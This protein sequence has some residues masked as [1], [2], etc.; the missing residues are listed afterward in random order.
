MMV[1]NEKLK[2]MRYIG[3][4]IFKC[5][6]FDPYYIVSAGFRIC[7]YIYKFIL[8]SSCSKLK[9]LVQPLIVEQN[10][11]QSGVTNIRK[12]FL[13]NLFLFSTGTTNCKRRKFSS[14]FL[15]DIIRRIA[16]YSSIHHQT[17]CICIPGGL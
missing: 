5:S 9:I 2:H 7:S 8:S 4:N 17:D 12:Q 6:Y 3:K 16:T 1:L 14:L 11:R 15:S 10:I 13:P